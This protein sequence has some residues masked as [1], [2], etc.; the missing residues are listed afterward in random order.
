MT[1]TSTVRMMNCVRGY[2]TSRRFALTPCSKEISRSTSKNLRRTTT[3]ER[4]LPKSTMTLTTSSD[5]PCSSPRQQGPRS[6]WSSTMKKKEGRRLCEKG[7]RTSKGGSLKCSGTAPKWRRC[8]KSTERMSC[9]KPTA[10]SS[11]ERSEETIVCHGRFLSRRMSC[12]NLRRS[13]HQKVVRRLSCA[14][15]AVYRGRRSTINTSYACF[16]TGWRLLI[17]EQQEILPLSVGRLWSQ[18]WET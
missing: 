8:A 6:A 2:L 13:P 3:R 9:H 18:V 5:L 14:M 4:F 16:A 12:H 10:A 17:H 7:M 1:M 11:P 15:V